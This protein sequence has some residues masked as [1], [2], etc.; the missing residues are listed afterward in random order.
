M[1]R[2]RNIK[3][4]FFTN[5]LLGTEEPMVGMTFVGLWC[6]ADRDGILEDRPLRIKAELFP[7]RENLDVNGYL[8]VLQ[9]L[10]FIQRYV[11]DGLGYIQIINFQKH[12]N[13]HHT[14]K[15][16]N[17]P[18][19]QRL[20]DITVKEPLCNGETQVSKRSDSFIPDS[21]IP[22]SLIPERGFTK[23]Q[24]ATDV[25][26]PIPSKAGV[27]CLALK[28][29]G[30]GSVSPS[31]PKLQT[32]IESGAE[33]GMFVDAARAAKERG[34]NTFNYILAIVDGQ[35]RDAHAMAQ[36]ERTKPK[37]KSETTYQ[38]SMRERWE[39]ATGTSMMQSPEIIDITPSQNKTV[40]I[41]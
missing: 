18:K 5:E 34:K 39:E 19:Y 33:V 1:A 26:R 12:Q 23:E 24:N 36:L 25:A 15:P 3:P 6:L 22:D 8:T 41:A 2:A 7:Y 40:R 13:P 16:K 27:I 30:V 10:G 37:S 29:E 20:T 28:S 9:R 31:S 4:S 38:R 35:M 11:V 17:Y 32:L 21:L 14:E